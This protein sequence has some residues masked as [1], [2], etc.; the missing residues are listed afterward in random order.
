MLKREVVLNHIAKSN[1]LTY[2]E[3]QRFIVEMNGL[4]Y[5][6]KTRYGQRR[7]RGYWND[8]LLDTIYRVGLLNQYCKK[9]GKLYFIK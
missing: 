4:N 3:I 2:G 1:G 8:Y 6:E 5:D 9:V 7:Y